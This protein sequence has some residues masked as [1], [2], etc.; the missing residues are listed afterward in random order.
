MICPQ[1][2]ETGPES[3]RW[4]ETFG[5]Y[6]RREQDH[7]PQLSEANRAE[8]GRSMGDNKGEN[9]QD[10]AA[11]CWA[12]TGPARPSDFPRHQGQV[13]HR[14]RQV[15]LE[16]RLGASEIAGLA[17]AQMDQSGQP[18]FHHHSAR[19]IFVI[20]GAL[21]QCP[22]LL[23]QGFLEMDQHPPSLPAFGRDA[24]GPQW[25]CHTFGPV[26]LEGPQVVDPS[27][28]ISPL[29]PPARWCG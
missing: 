12:A 24:L 29:F 20:P 22:G 10:D 6:S 8:I 5:Q 7:G 28:A 1:T 23:Q 17:D 2:L 14:G 19:S 11:A 25:T 3:S 21:L 18:V 9:I 15:Q 27:R 16:S 4:V 13:G 26:E